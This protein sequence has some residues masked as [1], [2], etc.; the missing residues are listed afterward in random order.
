MRGGPDP[1]R[2]FLRIALVL[3]AVGIVCFWVWHGV[4]WH[5]VE[6]HTGTVNESGPY[7]GFFSG[8]GS[9][10]G[11]V[12]LIAGVIALYRQHNCHQPGCWRL[13]K[14]ETAEGY[15]LCKKCVGCSKEELDLHEIHPDHL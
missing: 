9:D 12:T 7:Y 10:I 8:F 11:E 2:T 15:K 5:W 14:H 13:A 1:V 4:A 3:G 6:V